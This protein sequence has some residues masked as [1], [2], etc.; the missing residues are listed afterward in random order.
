M[1]IF[2][3]FFVGLWGVVEGGVGGVTFDNYRFGR[4]RGAVSAGRGEP[5]EGGGKPE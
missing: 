2:L 3:F 4:C 5:S 1:E